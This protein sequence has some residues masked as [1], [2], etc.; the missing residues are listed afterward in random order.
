MPRPDEESYKA[1]IKELEARGEQ[2]RQSLKSNVKF[3][4]DEEKL[5]RVCLK[6][7]VSFSALSTKIGHNPG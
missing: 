4:A 1:A 5:K 3:T 2:M 6:K 7:G